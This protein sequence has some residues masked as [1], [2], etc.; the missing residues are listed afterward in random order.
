MELWLCRIVHKAGYI[1]SRGVFEDSECP[2]FTDLLTGKN[3]LILQNISTDN[4]G[5]EE[6]VGMRR[7]I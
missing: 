2:T 6:T 1:D 4:K 3:D 7:L 5:P